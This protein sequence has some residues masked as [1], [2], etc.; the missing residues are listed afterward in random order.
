MS[1]RVE[2]YAVPESDTLPDWMLPGLPILVLIVAALHG[3]VA[4]VLPTNDDDVAHLR[5]RP[6]RRTGRQLHHPC[7]PGHKGALGKANVPKPPSPMCAWAQAGPGAR[8]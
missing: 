5:A 3:V 8:V 2:F 6:L 4:V 7:A 1:R